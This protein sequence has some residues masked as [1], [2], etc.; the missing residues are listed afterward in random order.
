MRKT[1]VVPLV[2][3]QHDHGGASERALPFARAL[4]RLGETSVTLVSVIEVPAEY[5]ALAS[6]LGVEAGAQP[7]WIAERKAYLKQVAETFPDTPVKTVVAIGTPAN[8]I[9][10]ILHELEDPIL[11]MS[12]HARTGLARAVLG[13]V[14][15]RVVHEAPCPVIVIPARN[16]PPRAPTS[17]DKVLVPLD[18]SPFAEEG[19][20][21]TIITLGPKDMTFHLL[22]VIKPLTDYTGMVSH[23]YQQSA[24]KWATEYLDGIVARLQERGITA[25]AEIT[26]GRVADEIQRVA[27]VRNCDL[28]AMS[29]HGRSGVRRLLFGSIAEEVLHESQIPLLLHRPAEPASADDK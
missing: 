19:L 11:V 17:L 22:H 25:E 26:F 3:P 20:E 6:A 18:G 27:S 12:S 5:E 24:Q 9:L 28:I 21:Q 15:F 2:A 7:Q 23:E 10:E 14:T 13:S 29:T 8:A 1:I 4:A 16:V